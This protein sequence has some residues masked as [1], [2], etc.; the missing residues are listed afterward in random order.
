MLELKS[1]RLQQ[2]I[3]QIE[4]VKADP[5]TV[6]LGEDVADLVD[7][8]V[9]VQLDVGDLVLLGN[10]PEVFSES[11]GVARTPICIPG[12]RLVAVMLGGGFL[13]APVRLVALDPVRKLPPA[14]AHDRDGKHVALVLRARIGE[15]VQAAAG[16]RGD[17]HPP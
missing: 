6:D 17:P 3:D 5:A 15:Q 4:H 7:F 13:A 11:A 14:L 16:R 2:R 8:E 1:L 9:A 12:C 10:G